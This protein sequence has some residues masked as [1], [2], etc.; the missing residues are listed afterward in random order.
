M[1]EAACAVRIP[2]RAD[3]PI[4]LRTVLTPKRGGTGKATAIIGAGSASAAFIRFFA[5]P[6]RR[7]PIL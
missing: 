1:R 3:E 4:S 6:K 5:V 7:K 2:A